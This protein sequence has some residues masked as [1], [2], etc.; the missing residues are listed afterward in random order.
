VA[1]PID[2]VAV[3]GNGGGGFRFSLVPIV[4]D[5]RLH[6]ITL[7]GFAAEPCDPSLRSVADYADA[8]GDRCAAL[9]RPVVLGHG[10]G[11]SIAL[12]LASRRPEVMAGL[13]L[14][15]P[16]GARLDERLFPKLMRI[17]GAK[18]AVQRAISSPVLRPLLA[19]KFG[20]S[21]P[22]PFVD[23]FF[24]EYRQ[25]SVFGQM[26][27]IITA[28][29]FTS[30]R[31]HDVPTVLLWG[32]RD[33]TLTVDQLDAFRPLCRNVDTRV[34]DEWGHFPMVDQPGDYAA[35]IAALARRLIGS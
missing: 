27:D 33:R 35:E 12:D 21:V 34:V 3:H 18:P 19:R 26:F 16:V 6:A 7:P 15:A 5:M 30:L 23:R 24:H 10:I 29:W 31:P 14:H 8:L 11:G 17:P 22:R 13:I 20:S 2:V 4:D 32:R 28:E 9:G 25:C 1:E